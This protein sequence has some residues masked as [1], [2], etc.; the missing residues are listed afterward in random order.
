MSWPLLV[1]SMVVGKCEVE[2][3][4]LDGLEVS[5]LFWFGGESG[6]LKRGG[7]RTMMTNMLFDDAERE[8]Q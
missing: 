7:I 4:W 8:C 2:R 1:T 5:K 3:W 6:R